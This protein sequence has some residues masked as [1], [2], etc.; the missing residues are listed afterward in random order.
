MGGE[1]RGTGQLKMRRLG[2]KQNHEDSQAV[3]QAAQSSWAVSI[4][5]CLQD[6]TDKAL[7]NLVQSQS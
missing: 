5:G 2:I 6:L 3:E 1:G 7:N 4:H